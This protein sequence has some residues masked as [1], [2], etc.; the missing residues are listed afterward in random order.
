MIDRI[1]NSELKQRFSP[2]GSELFLHQRRLLDILIYVDKLCREWGISYWLSSGT[3]LGAVRHGGFIPWD[4]DVD[5]EMTY[6]DYKRFERVMLSDPNYDIQTRRTDSFYAAPYAKIRDKNSRIVESPQD[7][8]YKYKG[9]YIDVFIIERNPSLLISAFFSR[10]IWRLIL[11]GGVAQSSSQK[12]LFLFKKRC[13]YVVRGIMRL[14]LL[15]VPTK[16]YRHTLGSGFNKNV[17]YIHEIFPLKEISFENHSFYIAGNYDMYL[18]RM[19]GDYEQ[20]P[21]LENLHPHVSNVVIDI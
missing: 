17:R 10:A 2:Q 18:K 19:Y 6:A 11:Q 15:S 5:I 21:D 8:N 4:D 20:L 12:R 13:V 9:I 14:L 1:L 16:Q 3:A 7:G